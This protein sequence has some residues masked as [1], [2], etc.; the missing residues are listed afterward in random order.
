MDDTAI[1]TTYI[2]R[3]LD[4]LEKMVRKG[5]IAGTNGSNF[6]PK[7]TPKNKFVFDNFWRK[8]IQ[9]S[10]WLNAARDGMSK[11]SKKMTNVNSSNGKK[12]STEVMSRIEGDS[13]VG[14]IVILVT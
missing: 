12:L 3:K 13:D 10:R 2:S 4:A 6:P 9:Y 1:T 5:S 14:E 7:D 11:N 8:N